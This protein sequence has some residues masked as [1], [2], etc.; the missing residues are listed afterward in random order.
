[1]GNLCRQAVPLVTA[2]PGVA[3]S[4]PTMHGAPVKTAREVAGLY[5]GAGNSDDSRKDY[6]HQLDHF[7]GQYCADLIAYVEALDGEYPINVGPPDGETT[8]RGVPADSLA[9]GC[10]RAEI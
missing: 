6:I 9:R 5:A 3:L 2:L 10:F 4:G 8:S 7:S 1:M